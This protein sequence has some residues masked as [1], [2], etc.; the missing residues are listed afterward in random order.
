M[1]PE[2][3][4]VEYEWDDNE[5][6]HSGE[7]VFGNTF[8]RHTL[9]KRTF[10]CDEA[11]TYIVRFPPVQEVPKVD[12][13]RNTDSHD[14]K[15]TVDLGRPS[16]SHEKASGKHPSPPVEGEFA[17]DASVSPGHEASGL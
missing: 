11:S 14:G 10:V 13:D 4:E 12:H 17:T 16:A 5:T 7:E 6:N 15:D 1:D 9:E 8:L 2:E 3:D